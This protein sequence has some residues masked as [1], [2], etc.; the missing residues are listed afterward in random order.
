MVFP[1]R[2]TS[3]D[4][5]SVML[6]PGSEAVELRNPWHEIFVGYAGHWPLV[7]GSSRALQLTQCKCSQ[8]R[9]APSGGVMYRA[10]APLRLLR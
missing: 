10:A 5:A 7:G 9:D 8:Q 4:M 2:R 1:C 3:D 6:L